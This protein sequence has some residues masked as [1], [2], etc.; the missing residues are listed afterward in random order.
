MLHKRMDYILFYQI[1]N[2]HFNS[3]YFAFK[4]VVKL[5]PA[6]SVYMVFGLHVFLV[7]SKINM[8]FL[9][10]LYRKPLV[11]M[12][13]V[14]RLSSSLF[15]FWFRWSNA[16]LICWCGMKG[17]A[18]QRIMKLNIVFSVCRSLTGRTLVLSV[19]PGLCSEILKRDFLMTWLIL[20]TYSLV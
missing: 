19:Q 14:R 10:P 17:K 18:M 20:F 4:L 9:N 2:Y 15:A 1:I 7:I 16:V 6:L 12:Y 8:E 11:L 13:V 5:L 3:E